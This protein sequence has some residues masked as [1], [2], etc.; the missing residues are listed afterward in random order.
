MRKMRLDFL[1]SECVHSGSC[2]LISNVVC[3]FL[4][5]LCVQ[6]TVC[7]SVLIAQFYTRR[8]KGLMTNAQ[9][10][11]KLAEPSRAST[12]LFLCTKSQFQDLALGPVCQ[13]GKTQHTHTLRY[14]ASGAAVSSVSLQWT[15]GH[16]WAAGTSKAASAAVG[17]RLPLSALAGPR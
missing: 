17:Q 5:S 7:K 10:I 4:L 14:F 15:F 8:C 2:F 6:P 3:V 12:I 13:C 1:S 9:R 11:G 16:V